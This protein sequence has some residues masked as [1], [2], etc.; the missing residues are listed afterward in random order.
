MS[1]EAASENDVGVDGD[2]IVGVGDVQVDVVGVAAV[3]AV[4]THT[5]G[6]AFAPC[7]A[8]RIVDVAFATAAVLALSARTAPTALAGVA[9]VAAVDF[10]VQDANEAA[11]D[12]ITVEGRIAAIE[13]VVS[14]NA[15]GPASADGAVRG[16]RLSTGPGGVGAIP[17]MWN[18]LWRRTRNLCAVAHGVGAA[19]YD[20][21][22]HPRSPFR[23]PRLATA[24]LCACS[25]VS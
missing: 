24:G 13:V 9:A 14:Q 19:P 25:A 5:T 15:G 22:S 21:D 4:A 17:S 6:A 23:M 2:G 11:D 8:R 20:P 1:A 16:S 18:D 7:A 12:D 3:A 10:D